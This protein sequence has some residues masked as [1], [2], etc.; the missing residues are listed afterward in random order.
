MVPLSS[1]LIAF[2]LPLW[3]FVRCAG[4]RGARRHGYLISAVSFAACGVGLLQEL[5]AVKRRLLAGDLSGLEDTIDA[6]ILISV[7]LLVG[8]VLLNLI[9]LGASY[10]EDEP[11]T[12]A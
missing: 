7:V 1:F 3:A 6:V 11:G 2:G 5:Y 8:T 9:Y 10:E 4:R 12:A